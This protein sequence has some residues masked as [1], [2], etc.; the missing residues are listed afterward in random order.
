MRPYLQSD[1]L[2]FPHICF[3]RKENTVSNIEHGTE[4]TNYVSHRMFCTRNVMG[5]MTLSCTRSDFI[6]RLADVG[7]WT[8]ILEAKN[9]PRSRFMLKETEA[10]TVNPQTGHN[11]YLQEDLT[12]FSSYLDSL[13][14]R[15]LKTCTVHQL[16]FLA[17]N[18]DLRRTLTKVLLLLRRQVWMQTHSKLRICMLFRH[19]NA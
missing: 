10:I 13:N 2:C 15:I 11:N 9:S 18:T 4:S 19:Q 16:H 6:I 5:N 3:T 14:S 17:D 7:A 1:W 12:S 8:W